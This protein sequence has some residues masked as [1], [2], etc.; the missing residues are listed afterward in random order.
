MK[1]KA[2]KENKF[3]DLLGL[4]LVRELVYLLVS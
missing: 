3:Q 1:I 4:T 2:Q